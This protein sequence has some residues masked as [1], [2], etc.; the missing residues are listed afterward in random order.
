MN[1]N[2]SESVYSTFVGGDRHDAGKDI[3]LDSENNAYVIGGT[4]SSDFPTTPGCFDDSYNRGSYYDSDVF[5]FKV[6]ADG[7]NLLYSTFVGGNYSDTRYSIALDSEN[8]AYITG[9][10]YSS[11]FPTTSGCYDGSKNDQDYSDVFVFKLN[12]DGSNLLYST[13]VGGNCSDTGYSIA[14]DS[15]NNVYITGI[16]DSYDFPTTS[17]CFDDSQLVSLS[18]VFVF[19]IDFGLDE[20]EV[21]K[22][23]KTLV[24][25]TFMIILVLSVL[26]LLYYDTKS[27]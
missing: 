8:N 17:G 13:F 7:S 27:R 25:L 3:A 16:T 14:L 4:F 2:G 12:Q 18:D 24:L 6:N 15:E 20:E 10:T 26:I 22:E 9:R 11:D 5:V 23:N 1:S 21:Q 19:K